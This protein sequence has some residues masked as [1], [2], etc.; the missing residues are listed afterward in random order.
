MAFEAKAK[1]GRMGACIL[2]S[3]NYLTLQLHVAVKWGDMKQLSKVRCLTLNNEN[4][5]KKNNLTEC[6]FAPETA[7]PHTLLSQN[8]IQKGFVT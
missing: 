2:T 7:G 4:P 1:I 3:G 5:F 8:K 6:L